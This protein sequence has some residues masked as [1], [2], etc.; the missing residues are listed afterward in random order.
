MRAMS[1]VRMVAVP[2]P[3][4][5]PFTTWVD[6]RWIRSWRVAPVNLSSPSEP[7]SISSAP[8]GA[9]ATASFMSTSRVIVVCLVAKIQNVN[10]IQGNHVGHGQPGVGV[11]FDGRQKG[12]LIG[13]AGVGDDLGQ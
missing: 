2:W 9:A 1:L 12:G 3:A 7:R 11:L 5:S 4:V 13:V 8:A 6:M 10:G